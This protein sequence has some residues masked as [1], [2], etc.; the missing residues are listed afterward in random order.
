MII[1]VPKEIKADE[2][3]VAM[4]PVGAELLTKDGHTA[5]V[6]HRMPGGGDYCDSLRDA[7]GFARPSAAAYADE[8]DSR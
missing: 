3:R 4:L 6:D 7:G 8:R 1:G 5:P 2:Y